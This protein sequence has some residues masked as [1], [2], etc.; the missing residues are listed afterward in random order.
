[1][2]Y[3]CL[4]EMCAST[5]VTYVILVHALALIWTYQALANVSPSKSKLYLSLC[6]FPFCCCMQE[7]TINVAM[8]LVS[9]CPSCIGDKRDNDHGID[10]ICKANSQN[11]KDHCA[12]DNV[13]L[14]STGTAPFASALATAIFLVFTILIF[15][16]L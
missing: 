15:P 10:G 6:L 9:Y 13:D 12:W 4:V 16:A 8:K 14:P 11:A 3:E 2:N 5:I 7:L 1:M